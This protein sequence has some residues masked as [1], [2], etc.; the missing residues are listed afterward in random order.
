MPIRARLSRAMRYGLEVLEV[1]C[2]V[3]GLTVHALDADS[4]DL[5]QTNLEAVIAA[6]RTH[7]HL[8]RC[9][10]VLLCDDRI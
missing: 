8:D 2:S 5:R 7:P 6:R 9:S 10:T 1:R 3:R 4:R